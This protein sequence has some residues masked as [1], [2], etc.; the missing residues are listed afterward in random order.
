MGTPLPPADILNGWSLSYERPLFNI[1]QRYVD[2]FHS[3][4][5]AISKGFFVLEPLVPSPPRIY[6]IP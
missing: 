6:S 2:C 1:H 4:D 5:M 3:K